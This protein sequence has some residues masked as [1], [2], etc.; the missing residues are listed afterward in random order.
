MGDSPFA[1]LQSS[2]SSDI[3]DVTMEMMSQTTTSLLA[4]M[5]MDVSRRAPTATAAGGASTTGCSFHSEHSADAT[6]RPLRPIGYL[7]NVTTINGKSETLRVMGP[8]EALYIQ[9]YDGFVTK[10]IRSY[11]TRSKNALPTRFAE[12]NADERREALLNVDRLLHR[13][14]GGVNRSMAVDRGE[15][16]SSMPNT[17][18]Q[19]TNPSIQAT[20]AMEERHNESCA[21]STTVLDPSISLLDESMVLLS[22]EESI[23][24]HDNANAYSVPNHRVK[25]FEC[26]EEDISRFSEKDTNKPDSSVSSIEQ[27]RHSQKSI[28]ATLATRNDD[29]KERMPSSPDFTSH[30]HTGKRCASHS[31]KRGL[32]SRYR[33]S[34]ED[35]ESALLRHFGGD[36]TGRRWDDDEASFSCG[37]PIERRFSEDFSEEEKDTVSELVWKKEK[38]RSKRGEEEESEEASRF[39]LYDHTVDFSND[40]HDNDCA[41]EGRHG[42]N[43]HESQPRAPPPRTYSQQSQWSVF[44][45]ADPKLSL[46]HEEEDE[47][48][49]RRRMIRF[50]GYSQQMARTYSNSKHDSFVP[51]KCDEMSTESDQ[52]F[53]LH[54]KMADMAVND[55]TRGLDDDFDDEDPIQTVRNLSRRAKALESQGVDSSLLDEVAP[56]DIRLREGAHFRMDPLRCRQVNEKSQ[57][58]QQR[59]QKSVK[60]PQQQ[61]KTKSIMNSNSKGN[62]AKVTTAAE[63]HSSESENSLSDP[64][65]SFTDPISRF[66][67]RVAARLN[68]AFDFLMEKERGAHRDDPTMKLH[69][70]GHSESCGVLLSMPIQQILS[71]TSKLLLQTMKS[72]RSHQRS[73]NGL[74]RKTK[75]STPLY[76]MSQEQEVLGGGTLIVL[77]GK[78][79]IAQWEVA[80]REYTSLSVMNHAELQSNL[81]KLANTAAKCAG[82]DVVLSTRYF[83]TYAFPFVSY[84]AIKAKEVTVPVNECG[85]AIL[86]SKAD[87]TTTN[88]EGGGGGWLTSRAADSQSGAEAPRKCH[89]LSVLHRMSWHR[90][91]LMDVLGR[92]GFLT[93]PGT[94]RAQAAV[95]INALS[96]FVIFEKEGDAKENRKPEEKFK[97]DRRQ[98]RSITAALQ[99]PAS[100]KLDKFLSHFVMDVNKVGRG[101]DATVCHNSLSESNG[102]ASENGYY[103][104]EDE[105]LT[106][107][108]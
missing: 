13:C 14:N 61:Q 75:R 15:D 102:S 101:N 3:L 10:T 29:R 58:Q 98:L 23:G 93:K 64:E 31:G 91:I 96:R 86:D 76:N 30:P 37:S 19:S 95:A 28:P 55:K 20:T 47:S 69:V 90:L 51:D 89:Q 67:T 6:R 100:V 84:D 22:D 45:N 66:P 74:S 16:S 8:N 53:S 104:S 60:K 63:Y 83:S 36:D 70:Q 32:K 71:I 78:E 27:T 11:S 26:R 2:S 56:T 12:M 65:P 17:N 85:C 40:C 88:A 50:D 99:M 49:V 21:E 62:R 106:D 5:A 52:R 77:R 48:P 7:T 25:E 35:A 82:F 103:L 68:T 94:A 97:D 9:K 18:R 57:S 80:L 33:S 38:G 81:R 87:A 59:G 42:K 54:K 73:M 41:Y 107:P 108:Y 24:H 79:D 4:N 1:A 46:T 39:S 92:Q 44:Q 34:S 105:N 43:G 72:A